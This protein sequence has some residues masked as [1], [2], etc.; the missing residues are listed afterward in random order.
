MNK[1]F[2]KLSTIL[3]SLSISSL[4]ILANASGFN[5]TDDN[6]K[7][8]SKELFTQIGEKTITKSGEIRTESELGSGI[9]ITKEESK[10]VSN[11]DSTTYIKKSKETEIDK[12]FGSRANL[13]KERSRE[14]STQV[15]GS[16][17]TI[18]REIEVEKELGSEA[19]ISQ[20]NKVSISKTTDRGGEVTFDS[21]SGDI[22]AIPGGSKKTPM[23]KRNRKTK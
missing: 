14:I 4:S 13:E 6:D 10:Q 2:L 19:E 3:C 20:D 23:I 15:N 5:N 7:E 11:Q 16:Y 18:S 12:E 21:G 22:T 9:E 8:R 1:N 17:V